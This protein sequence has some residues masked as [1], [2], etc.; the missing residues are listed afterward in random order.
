MCQSWQV[1]TPLFIIQVTSEKAIHGIFQ[2][3]PGEASLVSCTVSWRWHIHHIHLGIGKTKTFDLAAK[4][5]HV[6]TWRTGLS[7]K[8]AMLPKA[9]S[10][11]MKGLRGGPFDS[12]Q[13]S[14]PGIMHGNH[15]LGS[16][17][18]AERS[19]GAIGQC[20]FESNPSNEANTRHGS[21]APEGAPCSI[22][23]R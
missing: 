14:R 17:P 5:Q 12:A 22:T 20:T 1:H 23:S 10:L 8:T 21:L 18:G 7:T 4:R 13:E 6:L 11:A 16:H 19:R 9:S 3:L 2:R 15:T